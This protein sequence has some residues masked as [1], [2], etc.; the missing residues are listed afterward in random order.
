MGLTPW[1]H[2]G[3]VVDDD[4]YVNQ[5]RLEQDLQLLNP[6]LPLFLGIKRY[7]STLHPG[8]DV[9]MRNF[10]LTETFPTIPCSFYCM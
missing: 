4:T 5:R 6:E 2:H 3:L 10:A 8:V 9:S 7:T 1:L